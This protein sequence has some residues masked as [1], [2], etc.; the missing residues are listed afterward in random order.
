ML[1]LQHKIR[2]LAGASEGCLELRWLAEVGMSPA[3]EQPAPRTRGAEGASLG[4]RGMKCFDFHK[5]KY[6]FLT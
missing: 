4:T 5:T 1:Q 6:V 2:L 3:R